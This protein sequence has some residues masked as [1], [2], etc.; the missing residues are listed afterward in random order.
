VAEVDDEQHR[1][2]ELFADAYN[3]SVNTS[4]FELF[5][6]GIGPSSSH[7]VG[8]MRAALRF[9]QALEHTG[10]LADVSQLTVDLYGS[11]ALTG[12]GHGTD[13]AILLGLTGEAPDTVDPAVIEAELAAIRSTGTLY[14]LDREPIPLNET[15]HLLFHRDQMYPDPARQTHPNGMR[16]SALTADAV[17]LAQE[18]FYSIGGGFILSA[19]EFEDQQSSKGTST[20]TVPYPFSSAAELLSIAAAHKLTIADLLLAN[21]IALLADT[22]I[23]RP[24]PAEGTSAATAEDQVKASI[25]TIWRTMQTCTERGLATEGILPGGL[26]VRRRAPRLAQRLEAGSSVDPLAPMDWVTVYAMA[27][28]EENAKRRPGR[29]CAD[30]RGCRIN[31]RDRALLHAVCGRS[32]RGR[33]P[34]LLSDCRGHW[35]SLQ[36]EC[37][38]LRSR[39]WLSG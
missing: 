20:R 28:N 21:E 27:V 24:P 25:L 16:F 8:P 22:S 6:I 26:N 2:A 17:L 9:V 13:R 18:V 15:Q 32:R 7:T 11:L 31:P 37:Q 5:K 23:R 36:R 35:H 29:H 30:Q 14:L 12:H 3:T 39:G 19:D 33:T 10:R 1:R 4:L 38:H 34:T